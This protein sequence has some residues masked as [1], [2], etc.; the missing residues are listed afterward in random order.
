ME[1]EN[2]LTQ[3]VRNVIAI[4]CFIIAIGCAFLGSRKM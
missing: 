4:L 1:L 3:D 2:I